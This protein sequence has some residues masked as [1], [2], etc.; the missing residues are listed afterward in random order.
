MKI[1]KE[2]LPP[3]KQYMN[4]VRGD[5]DDMSDRDR[6]EVMKREYTIALAADLDYVQL[7]A[8][9]AEYNVSLPKNPDLVNLSEINRKYALA[10]SYLTRVSN[11]E[12]NAIYVVDLWHGLKMSITE[13]IEARKSTMLIKSSVLSFPNAASQQAYVRAAMPKSYSLLAKVTR[14]HAEADAFRKMVDSKKKDLSSTIMNLKRQVEVM[15]LEHSLQ[16]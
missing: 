15:S 7:R 16:R 1:K 2:P 12:M 10:Q 4:K 8:E 5:Q 3:N 11:I 14:K 13:Y 9:M 6:V